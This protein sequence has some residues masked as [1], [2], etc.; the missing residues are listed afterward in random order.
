MPSAEA[1]EIKANSFNR[2]IEVL[3]KRLG[4]ARFEV[5]EQALSVETRALIARPPLPMA[6]IPTE[7]ST[8]L[9]EKALSVGFHGHLGELFE[10][11]REQF[12][13]DMSTLYRVFMRLASPHT[14][15]DRASAIFATYQRGGGARMSCTAKAPQSVDLF[16]EHVRMPSPAFWSYLRGSIHAVLEMSGVKGTEV[17]IVR[18]GGSEPSTLFRGSWR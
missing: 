18:G 12:K 14:L 13:G 8:E 2:Q 4:A 9:L 16:V 15:A 6:W 11:G 3:R 10:V 5:L 7:H 17:V 1:H